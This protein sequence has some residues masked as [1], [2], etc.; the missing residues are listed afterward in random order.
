MPAGK[1]PG[2]GTCKWCRKPILNPN[3]TVNTRRYWHP[4]CADDY[5]LHTRLD[6]QFAFLVD[7]DGKRCAQCGESP[8]RWL[9]GQVITV[10]Q[11][12]QWTDGGMPDYLAELWPRPSG[13][14][15]DR[16]PEERATGDQTPIERT[17][18]LQVDH[19]V[20]LWAVAH[21]PDDQRRVYYGP[22]NLWL[23]C[24]PCHK[25]KT[26]DEAARRARLRRAGWHKGV[27]HGKHTD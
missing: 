13:T 27:L 6:C 24:T 5:N 2:A 22:R 4:A 10:V 25:A 9:A 19:R 11:W 18:D 16:T 7:R 20:P 3:G 12:G 1:W 21:L 17:H 23:L 8:E 15:A 26:A 14:W